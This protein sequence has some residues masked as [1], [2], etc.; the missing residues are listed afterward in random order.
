[1]QIQ[2]GETQI[3]LQVLGEGKP[4]IFLHGWKNDKTIWEPILPYLLH[5]GKLVFLDLP[6]FGESKL[7]SLDWN[8]EDFAKV[9]SLL[10]KELEIKKPVIVGHSFGGRV[11]IKFVSLWPQEAEKLILIASGGIREKN[12]FNSLVFLSAKLG[13]LP[14][15]IPFFSPLFSPTRKLFYKVIRREDYLTA[16]RMK[17]IFLSIIKEDLTPLLP[18]ISIP[19]LII[20]GEK[21]RELPLKLGKIMKEKI[22]SSSLC[23]FKSCG[24]FPFLEKPEEFSKTVAK[25][26]ED[27]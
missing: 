11:A 5:L 7:P 12:I 10:I 24:H 9:V 16:G 8:L 17:K 14:F 1:M 3:S 4:I 26:L 23:I 2:L 21:D 6:G 15:K 18:K 20:W 27:D 13:K 19:T 25:F 22:P